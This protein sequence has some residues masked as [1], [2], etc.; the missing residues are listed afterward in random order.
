MRLAAAEPGAQTKR[1]PRFAVF[2][3][4]G[5]HLPDYPREIA[6]RMRVSKKELRVPVDVRRPRMIRDHV[7]EIGGENRVLQI[8]GKDVGSWSA[9]SEDAHGYRP[10]VLRV[11]ISRLA[12]VRR[13]ISRGTATANSEA[14]EGRVCN[15][16][17]RVPREA[18]SIGLGRPTN[19]EADPDFSGSAAV[20]HH[21][22]KFC[23]QG[24]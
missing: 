22:G 17:H 21:F 2:R 11:R 9:C 10:R 8:T 5:K 4:H 7:A 18:A 23:R 20:G 14:G 6:S 15:I 16:V 12:G 3:Q 24:W 13:S 19:E 1:Q